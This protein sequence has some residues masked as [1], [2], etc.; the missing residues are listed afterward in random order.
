MSSSHPL[1]SAS[2]GALPRE[3]RHTTS[4]AES[5]SAAVLDVRCACQYFQCESLLPD[6]INPVD[7]RPGS[8]AGY[9]P[10]VNIIQLER[11]GL[12][13]ASNRSFAVAKP[14][15]DPDRISTKSFAMGQNKPKSFDQM[16]TRSFGLERQPAFDQISNKGLVVRSISDAEQSEMAIPSWQNKPAADRV[17]V[18][19]FGSHTH[20]S[21][22]DADTMSVRN[23]G[24]KRISRSPSHSELYVAEIDVPSLGGSRRGSKMDLPQF[25]VIAATP[26]ME[27]RF[28]YGEHYQ[29]HPGGSENKENKIFSAYDDRAPPKYKPNEQYAF[30][31]EYPSP[32]KQRKM[33]N[34]QQEPMEREVKED[35]KEVA[36]SA[37]QIEFSPVIS[38]RIKQVHELNYHEPPDTQPPQTIK[39]AK[40]NF[41]NEKSSEFKVEA[42]KQEQSGP[43][44]NA[45]IS[46]TSSQS[47]GT[48]E[49]SSRTFNV[50][51]EI[52]NLGPKVKA[53][54][55]NL[56]HI[57][58]RKSHVEDVR[59]RAEDLPQY[60][61]SPKIDEDMTPKVP[62]VQ[63]E[64]PIQATIQ[65][66]KD[67]IQ[68]GAI[69]RRGDIVHEA[70]MMEKEY[71]MH[72]EEKEAEEQDME[73][74]L[75]PI[76]DKT[77]HQPP[78]PPEEWGMPSKPYDVIDEGPRFP[79]SP[80]NNQLVNNRRQISSAQS[81][82]QSPPAPISHTAKSLESKVL[83]QHPP[84][85]QSAQQAQIQQESTFQIDPANVPE[86]STASLVKSTEAIMAFTTKM[87]EPE[88]LLPFRADDLPQYSSSKFKPDSSTSLPRAVSE[89]GSQRQLD[90][91]LLRSNL[92][93]RKQYFTRTQSQDRAPSFGGS[94]SDMRSNRITK[95]VSFD[96][97][98]KTLPRGIGAVEQVSSSISREKSDWLEDTYFKR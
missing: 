72:Y 95:T 50:A 24:L 11:P 39:E 77:I 36:G 54:A 87:A 86:K 61:P 9:A 84:V 89:S 60:Q 17:S 71:T 41:S 63:P 91:R 12:H 6:R 7:S 85:P 27:A 3:K 62:E 88:P 98:S 35:V 68:E 93:R 52:A 34:N 67:V 96:F 16:S 14:P 15:P 18:R 40:P 78:P 97:E 32:V 55:E 25:N 5:T 29:P 48:K 83:E 59:F 23:F 58:D 75:V 66:S 47:S 10:D 64:A 81:L 49:P 4:R 22:R 31:L 51:K 44:S 79:S 19:S 90:K 1:R 42:S 28:P 94:M 56:I 69:L 43:A 26:I 20:I 13:Y 37:P 2:V 33:E 70:T 46:F 21:R 8:S 74:Y 76:I 80:A 92:L 30:L 53:M 38:Q 65:Q 57:A 45:S 82:V 73:Q